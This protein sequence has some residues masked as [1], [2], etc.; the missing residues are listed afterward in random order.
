M[1]IYYNIHRVPSP[2]GMQELSTQPWAT[3]NDIT[4]Q[5]Q[6][7]K[8][9]KFFGFS[10]I[11]KKPT[12]MQTPGETSKPRFPSV[13]NPSKYADMQKTKHLLHLF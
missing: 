11:T 6:K 8:L 1:Y 12:P 5:V 3:E 13:T 4:S 7:Q 10:I 2:A 9:E